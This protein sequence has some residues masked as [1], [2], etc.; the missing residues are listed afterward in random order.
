MRTIVLFS[1]LALLILVLSCASNIK[2]ESLEDHLPPDEHLGLS[3]A[4]NLIGFCQECA[5][6]CLRKKRVIGDCRKFVCH[7][8]KRTIGVGL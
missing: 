4:T 1:T 5:H 7:C 6:H 8:S 2:A 3:H